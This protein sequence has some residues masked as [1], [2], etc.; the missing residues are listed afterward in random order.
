MYRTLCVIIAL[1]LAV[2]PVA[3]DEGKKLTNAELK[4]MTSEML[5]YAGV[6]YTFQNKWIISL[7]PNGTE[8]AYWTNGASSGIIKRK[9]RIDGDRICSKEEVGL[10]YCREWRKNG[11]RIESWTDNRK[12]GFFYILQ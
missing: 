7:F 1:L 3:A 6:S 2:G 4:K 10:E 8:E 5:F 12:T 11:D 9:W